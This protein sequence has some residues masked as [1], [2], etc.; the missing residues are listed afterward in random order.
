MVDGAKFVG[1]WWF[2]EHEKLALETQEPGSKHFH[3]IDGRWTYQ[4]HKYQRCLDFLPVASRRCAIDVGAHIGQWSWVMARDFQ[5]LEAFEPVELHR[6][7]WLANMGDLLYRSTLYHSGLSDRE[8]RGEMVVDPTA[9]GN[10]HLHPC[11]CSNVAETVSMFDRPTSTRKTRVAARTHFSPQTVALK[12]LDSFELEEVDFI[13]IDVEGYELKVC[14]GAEA[15][16]KRWRPVMVVEQKG[17]DKKFYGTTLNAACAWLQHELGMIV[18]DV[19]VGD[20]IM[21]WPETPGAGT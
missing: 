18:L 2:P 14:Q 7:C 11:G 19:I 3:E 8:E 16:I 5:L 1:G 15:T 4:F 10:S 21:G 9:T 20:Y 13:K 17:H 12:T 6:K